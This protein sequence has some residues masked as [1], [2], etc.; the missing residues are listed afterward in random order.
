MG[1]L[2][3]CQ[4]RGFNFKG[5]KEEEQAF[6]D[7]DKPVG[8]DDFNPYGDD[9][10]ALTEKEFARLNRY[11]KM[12]YTFPFYKMDVNG[13]VFKVK[14]ALLNENP[15]YKG[16]LY[17]CKYV[18]LEALQKSFSTHSSWDA[19]KDENS[20][21]VKFLKKSC[22][23]DVAEKFDVWKLRI[24]GIMMCNG[25]PDET[26][27]EL[28]TCIND[29]GKTSL[30]CNDRDLAPTMKQL[31]DTA[32]TIVFDAEETFLGQ[33]KT[34]TDEQIKEAREE[35]DDII[36]EFLDEVFDTESRLEREEFVESVAKNQAWIFD[37]NKVRERL[38]YTKAV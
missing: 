37:P 2:C 1:A 9:R 34:V 26:A 23:D 15:E 4:G 24:L 22:Y 19:F 16:K 8:L 6:K 33:K 3:I 35:Y 14:I 12:E 25:D 10:R 13:Y 28:F 7:L 31:F 38:G 5:S 36:E 18:S 27:E 29:S 30:T 32:T 20:D 11:E 17:L 21:F